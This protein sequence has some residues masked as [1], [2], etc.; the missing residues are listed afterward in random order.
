M[1]ATW[2]RL[3]ASG[4]VQVDDLHFDDDDRGKLV[5]GPSLRLTRDELAK[6]KARAAE[7][8][9]P[10][11]AVARAAVQ[12]A[13]A[14]EPSESAKTCAGDVTSRRKVGAK[15]TNVTKCRK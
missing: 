5:R 1:H 11:N 15:K 8:G 10:Q 7:Q 6:L 12:V 13:L 4:K 14:S 9:V 3:R 2:R